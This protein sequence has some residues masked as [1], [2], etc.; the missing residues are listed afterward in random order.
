MQEYTFT[1]KFTSD[2][3]GLGGVALAS[4][5]DQLY[6][7]WTGSDHAINLIVS[8]DDGQS[9]DYSTKIILDEES[10]NRPALAVYQNR[11]YIAW[12]NTRGLICLMYSTD[13][14]NSFNPDTKSIS[15]QS[16]FASGFL[17]G[18]SHAEGYD[19]PALTVCQ[20]R[21]HVAWAGQD[22]HLNFMYSTDG[23]KSFDTGTQFI[24]PEK[25]YFH[26][27]RSQRA[28]NPPAMYITDKNYPGPALGVHNGQ[29]YCAWTGQDSSI[30]IMSSIDSGQTFDSSTKIISEQTSHSAPAIGSHRGQGVLC[31]Q[32]TGNWNPTLNLQLFAGGNFYDSSTAQHITFTD[33]TDRAPAILSHHGRLIVAWCGTN[34]RQINLATY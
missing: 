13:N 29:L 12:I 22:Q 18:T 1:Q 7:A 21:L 34:N 26:I 31:W 15:D 25:S 33:S 5:L 32:G 11:L 23:G 20:N 14:G 28:T 4:Y 8:R 2:E 6:I 16:T 30:N 9:F 3:L 24:S 17:A 19:G 10:Y 27:T